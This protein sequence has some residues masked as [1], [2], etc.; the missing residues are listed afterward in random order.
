MYFVKQSIGALA[1][2]LAIALLL[3]LA[4]GA[5]RM[6]R[7]PRTTRWLLVCAAVVAYLGATSVT[8]DLLLRPLERQ[9]P[10]LGDN[11]PQSPRYI[12]VLGSGYTPREGLPITAA[13]DEDGLT[14]IVEGVRLALHFGAVKLVVS[15]GAPSGSEAPAHGYAKLAH[16]LG[17]ADSTLMVLDT[18]LDTGAEAR[19]VAGLLGDT[20]FIL[21]TSAYHMP[22]AVR[23]MQRAG[24][25]PIP[26]PTGQLSY[27]IKVWDLERW[28]P[29]SAGLRKSERALHE[30]LGLAALTVHLG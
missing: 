4:A 10:A 27:R 29:S 6:L 22:R 23:Q 17:I 18:A 30:Y 16:E 8:G 9:Y 12:V 3:T 11:Q 15:G 5:L 1:S 13:I 24:A 20:P 28:L 25:H 21:V 14:R 7:R 2:P 19:A 26:A